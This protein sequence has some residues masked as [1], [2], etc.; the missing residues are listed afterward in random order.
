MVIYKLMTFESIIL[1]YE[2]EESIIKGIQWKFK[3]FLKSKIYRSNSAS[4]AL[5]HD[6][7]ISD[8]NVTE[9]LKCLQTRGQNEYLYTLINIK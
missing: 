8:I 1:C 3:W 9:L 4:C 7:N 6:I 5:N 2:G